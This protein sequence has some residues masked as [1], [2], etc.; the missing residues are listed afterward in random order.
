MPALVQSPAK[1]SNTLPGAVQQWPSDRFRRQR[2]RDLYAIAEPGCS[3]TASD[4][5]TS[6]HAGTRLEVEH[7]KTFTNRNPRRVALWN[8]CYRPGV[9]HNECPIPGARP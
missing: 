1:D 5:H 7:D 4:V 9:S 3:L 2:W 6:N 8:R